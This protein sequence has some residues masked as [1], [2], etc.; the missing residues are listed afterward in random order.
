M[1]PPNCWFI[2]KK[3]FHIF[4]FLSLFFVEN[5]ARIL[6]VPF[7]IP[8]T[9]PYV[10]IHCK[11]EVNWRLISEEISVW[12][13]NVCLHSWRR[14]TMRSTKMGKLALNSIFQL[15]KFYERYKGWLVKNVCCWQEKNAHF[16]MQKE[17]RWIRFEG[18]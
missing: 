12:K 9:V 6:V 7:R 8:F 18:F 16:V 17:T 5:K 11:C 2:I 13:R 4:L 3:F 15:W 1:L 10:D 14:Q